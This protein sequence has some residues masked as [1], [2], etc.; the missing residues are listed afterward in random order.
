MIFDPKD[1]SY[2]KTYHLMSSLV[3]PR[4][5]AWVSTVSPEG[6][7][8][9][10]PYSFFTGVSSNPPVLAVSI[11]RRRKSPHLKDTLHN[12]R[13]NGFFA[14]NSVPVKRGQQMVMTAADA[15]P[16]VDEFSLAGLTPVPCEKIKCPRIKESPATMECKVLD[17]IEIGRDMP[18]SSTL[19]LGEILLFHLDESVL[20]G[21][22]I[23]LQK[24]DP[25]GR[26]SSQ[27][28][29]HLSEIFEL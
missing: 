6:I 29:T 25:L 28:Y 17:L 21:D 23:N 14:V 2:N 13:D 1:H 24:L 26:L 3:V 5:I 9:L 27:F 7:N 15:E 10:A 18:G 8:N 12:I 4:P 11:G 16:D 20:D 19:I 22:R